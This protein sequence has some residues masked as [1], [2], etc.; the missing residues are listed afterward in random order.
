MKT[1]HVTIMNEY[2]QDLPIDDSNL[3]T[4]QMV[5]FPVVGDRIIIDD[6]DKCDV[7]TSEDDQI[8]QLFDFCQAEL[9]GNRF[10]FEVAARMMY[11]VPEKSWLCVDL[12]YKPIKKRIIK[13]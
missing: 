11:K 5:D 9:G 4:I 2:G 12:L 8:C 13:T 10:E 7:E 6:V 1:V 3:F